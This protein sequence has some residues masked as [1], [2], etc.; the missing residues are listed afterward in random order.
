MSSNSPCSGWTRREFLTLIGAA[1]LAPPSRNLFGADTNKVGLP[2]VH[3]LGTVI[4]GRRYRL[5]RPRDLL[6]LDLELLNLE[7]VRR[8]ENSA[9][10]LEVVSHGA[11]GFLILHFTGQHIAEQAIWDRGAQQNARAASTSGDKS[12]NDAPPPLTYRL[13]GRAGE[14]DS[15]LA[16]LQKTDGQRLR[17]KNPDMLHGLAG[18][19]I[20]GPT[21]LVFEVPQRRTPIRFELDE[22]LRVCSE[23]LDLVVAPGVAAISDSDNERAL[24]FTQLDGQLEPLVGYHGSGISGSSQP[25]SLSD[26]AVAITA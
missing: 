3:P 18:A 20:S 13:W 14:D 6:S 8:S 9:A 19:W 10:E 25:F 15:D 1:A 26:S 11:S 12:G 23:E 22:I 2:Q 5:L 4:A 21:Q 7:L 16:F 17:K 24:K